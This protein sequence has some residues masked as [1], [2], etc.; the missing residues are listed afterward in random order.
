MYIREISTRANV[1]KLVVW[2]FRLT[3]EGDALFYIYFNCLF[4]KFNLS[5]TS[6]LLSMLSKELDGTTS[7]AII[8]NITDIVAETYYY[9]TLN[10]NE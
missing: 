9:D 10:N 4:F 6:S 5:I 2:F 3:N 7:S 1:F 8:H